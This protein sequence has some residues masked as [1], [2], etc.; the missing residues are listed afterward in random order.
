LKR[1]SF[2]NGSVFRSDQ[3]VSVNLATAETGTHIQEMCGAQQAADVLC[4][5]RRIKM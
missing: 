3:R 4:S 5:E 2:L 1:E